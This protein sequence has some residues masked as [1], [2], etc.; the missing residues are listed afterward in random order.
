MT[1]SSTQTSICRTLLVAIAL[2]LAA[3]CGGGSPPSKATGGSG[4]RGGAG[5]S[6][7]RGVDPERTGGTS[8]QPGTGGTGTATGG[9]PGS[10]GSA[11][12]T[13]GAGA[14]DAPAVDASVEDV[15]EPDMQS[16]DVP[17][18]CDPACDPGE[19]CMMG[20]CVLV[21][22]PGQAKCPSG[23]ADLQIDG[24]NCGMCGR[25]CA[26]G[27]FCSQGMC[28]AACRDGETRCGTSCVNLNSNARNCGACGRSCA[29]IEVC[30]N[31]VC[32]C[33]SPNRVCNGACTNVRNNRQHCGACGN[34]CED[35]FV[36]NGTT[37]GCPGGRREC[38]NMEGQCVVSLNEC[39]PS[40]QI[41]C[42]GTGG[43]CVDPRSD[44]NNCNTCGTVC[45]GQ[46]SCT[47][48]R[49]ACPA[50]RRDCGNGVCAAAGACCANEQR[51][52]DGRC[53]AV[54]ACCS[55]CPTGTAC[56]NGSCQGTC[57]DSVCGTC[58]KCNSARTMCVNQD[59]NTPCGSSG[60]VCMDGT[61]RAPDLC[62][63]KNCGPCKKCRASDGMCEIDNA[64]TCTNPQG[65]VCSGGSCG[66][67]GGQQNCGGKCIP[68]CT[69][70]TVCDA[71]SQSCKDLCEGKTCGACKKCRA[72][73]GTCQPDDAA[74]CSD[75]Q[76][77][78][79]QAGTCG[80]N[81][82]TQV[83]CGGKCIAKPGQNM[84]CCNPS[85]CSPG[86]ACTNNVCT[87]GDGKLKCGQNCCNAD[88]ET[89]D[90]GTMMCKLKVDAGG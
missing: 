63:G 3:G 36:C 4:G 74:T 42:G 82:A 27:Q 54:T 43:G 52:G 79:C 26:A 46:T 38:P 64:A 11:G 88:T 62:A 6:G 21:C 24:A 35:D 49:C 22:T 58:R 12:G 68:N 84:A 77:G 14:V 20:Q 30:V 41:W 57:Q 73:D 67:P 44:N 18:T 28:V 59:N 56:I 86:F 15:I 66:C 80:C 50:G 19:V 40:P 61:C 9:S 51:C 87:C 60:M 45:P 78:T 48:R 90:S 32:Q 16:L 69:G 17:I 53:I 83:D 10:G 8:G 65:G 34:N 7:G 23:C 47:N 81:S 37:C 71:P 70:A 76:G 55:T 75:P 13:G 31:Q 72:S 25:T 85:H 29:G 5:G 33:A 1:M 2:A 89:C 39:C